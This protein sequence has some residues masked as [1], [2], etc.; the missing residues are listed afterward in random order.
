MA[1]EDEI[2]ERNHTCLAVLAPHLCCSCWNDFF[3]I[4]NNQILHMLQKK[5]RSTV[6][7]LKNGKWGCIWNQPIR[8]R[9]N[10][11]IFIACFPRLNEW[12]RLW[13]GCFLA[14]R[15]GLAD[16]SL[17]FSTAESA[18]RSSS[19]SDGRKSSQLLPQVGRCVSLFSLTVVLAPLLKHFATLIC[20][21][22]YG[23]ND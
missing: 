8:A 17:Y 9:S 15:L 5:H 4:N 1:K 22:S 20:Y 19:R 7:V 23:R 11:W 21:P 18:L 10:S 6:H 14:G 3:Q 2:T 16:G 13:R 12:R